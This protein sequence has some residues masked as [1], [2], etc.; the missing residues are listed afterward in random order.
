MKV[1]IA[2]PRKIS[3]LTGS[4]QAR[5]NNIC[6]KNLSVV[7]G[8][9]NGIDKAVQQYF[10]E[11]Q[12][13]DICIFATQGKARN[14]IGNWKVENVKVPDNIRGFDFYAA[15]DKK[16]AD[17][18][19]YGF[20]IWNGKSKG[21]LTNMINLLNLNKKT[22]LYFTVNGEFYCV[23]RYDTLKKIIELCD[24]ET[25]NLFN[26]LTYKGEGISLFDSTKY[27]QGDGSFC[28]DTP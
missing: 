17:C 28:I 6:N 14:N 23:N 27:I 20:M 11:R 19:D 25:R 13:E 4:V 1:F 2:G 21:T 9:A 5:L 3:R 18:A 12:Y 10:Y 7:V 24:R 16:M 8:D 22:L 15:K 26:E